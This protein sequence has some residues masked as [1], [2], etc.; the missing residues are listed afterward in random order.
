[1]ASVALSPS[2][3]P[4]LLSRL[5]IADVSPAKG[6]IS[7]EF[8]SYVKAMKEIESKKTKSRKEADEILQGYEQDLSVRQFLLT[9]LNPSTSTTHQTFR[10]PL[11][12]IEQSIEGIG[13]FPYEPGERKW[14]GKTLL[15]KGAKSKYINRRNIPIAEQYFPNLRLETLDAGHWVHVERSHEFLKLVTDFIQE[16]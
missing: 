4:D 11:H 1:V 6:P 14:E 5:I 12:Y 3:P 15:V 7:E 8:Q 10:I 13:D 9:N 2:L 16:P